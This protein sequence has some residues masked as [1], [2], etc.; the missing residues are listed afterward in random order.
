MT[1]HF[2]HGIIFLLAGGLLL[3]T[4]H[5]EYFEW[6]R[7][8]DEI[9]FEP[10][11]VA[12]LI[13]GSVNLKDIVELFDTTG[14]IHEFDDGL[15]YLAYSDT[16]FSVMA[17]TMISVPDKLVTEYYIDSDIDIPIWIGSSV[18]DT[19]PFV[20][21]EQFSFQLDGNDRVDS[22]LVKGGQIVMDINSTFEHAGL[23][24]ISSPHILNVNRDTFSTVIEI[25]D[26][27]GSFM[28]QQTFQLDG[29]LLQT[30][31]VNDTSFIHIN[32]KLD[33]INSGNPVNPDDFCSIQANFTN[34]GFYSVF[35]YID[36]RDLITEGGSF[37]ISIFEENPDLA[38]IIFNDPR[39]NIFTSSSVGIPLEVELSNVIATSSRDG[40]TV[41]LVFTEGHPFQ[42]SA[43]DIAQMGERV[44]SEININKNTCNIDELLASA[45][46]DITFSIIGRTAAG[47]GEDQHFILDTSKIDLALEILLPLD[48]KSTGFAF[49]DTM[50]FDVGEEGIDTSMIK[51]AQVS[52]TTLNELPIE[53]ALQ[54][55]LLDEFHEMV[56][57]I[58]DQDVVILG[59]SEVDVDGKL[60]QATEESNQVNFPAEKL[61]KL[62]EVRYMQ[63]EARLITSEL[64][65]RF[66]KLYS[67]YTLDFEISM[68]ANIRINTREL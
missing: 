18:G 31:E 37:E 46:S 3:T 4:C 58:F 59:A 36:S 7:L 34:L 5:K 42:L 63:V 2:L 28:D 22:I 66:V 1:R 53:L 25:S 23:L 45:P 49:E 61:G 21:Q 56:D 52:V 68:L 64:G 39:I 60:V 62:G 11:L 19:V 55:Y 35:G 57:S 24:T 30:T 50:E 12:P 8:S 13:H 26:A 9:E 47:S 14:Y 40:S 48:F 41:E 54:V 16:A 32:F 43:P 44:E 10:K 20:K 33:L 38:S 6:D 27:G 67:D 51:L 17:D 15:I 29:Y 65:D